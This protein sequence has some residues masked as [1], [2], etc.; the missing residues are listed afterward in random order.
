MKE[1]ITFKPGTMLNPIPA[2]MVSCGSTKEE[3]NIITVAWTGIVNSQPPMTYVSVRPDRHSHDI[4]ER[5][6]EFV[7]NL[8]TEE[9]VKKTDWCGVKSGRDEDK[10]EAMELTKLECSLLS[11]PMIGE[12]PVNLECRVVEVKRLGSHD[13]FLAEIVAV[14]ADVDLMD[15]NQ[16][17]CLER[18]HLIT[19]C[20]GHYYGLR[21][22]PLGR[23]GYSVMKPKTARR[24][25]GKERQQRRRRKSRQ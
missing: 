20:H 12:A 11:C 15:E 24:L 22:R 7:I 4:I 18:A 10:F 3:H 9:L 8:T 2:V 14:H 19:Y 21:K 1:K 13:M 23:F 6:G 25:A 16:R 5:N 17:L